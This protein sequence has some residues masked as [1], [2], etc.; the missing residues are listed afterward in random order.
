MG[1]NKTIKENAFRPVI[2]F[3]GVCNLCNGAVQ[4][5]I[6]RDTSGTFRFASLQSAAAAALVGPMGKNPADLD[7]ILLVHKGKVYQKSRAA[8]EI[9]RRMRGAW[10]LLYGLV[11]IPPFIR[12]AVYNW[13]ARN[14][15]RWFGRQESCMV[16]SPELKSR[17]LG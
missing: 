2:L 14:R 9:A 8:L 17:F 16:P 10:P 15:Y 3:D 6:K 12:D 1:G 4:F 11:I 13:V 5:V 7:S